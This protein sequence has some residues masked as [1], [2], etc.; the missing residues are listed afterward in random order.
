MLPLTAHVDSSMNS[1]SSVFKLSTVDKN[2]R[3]FPSWEGWLPQAAGVGCGS[4]QT[5]PGISANRHLCKGGDF[6]E[7]RWLAR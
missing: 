5:H 6:Q 3:L 1:R 7:I 4:R 2:A